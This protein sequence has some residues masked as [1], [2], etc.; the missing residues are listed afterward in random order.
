MYVDLS[1]G[2]E[3]DSTTISSTNLLISDN[4]ACVSVNVLGVDVNS[5]SLSITFDYDDGSEEEIYLN[6]IDTQGRWLT[7]HVRFDPG[8]RHFHVMATRGNQNGGFIAIDDIMILDDIKCI[9]KC[10]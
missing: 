1:F 6:Y 9:G 10:L 3:G 2:E 5:G 4:P 7:E 8:L